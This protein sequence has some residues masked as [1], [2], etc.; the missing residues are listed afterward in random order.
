MRAAS[1]ADLA[2]LTEALDTDADLIET[3]DQLAAQVEEAIDSYLG[4]RDPQYA[5]R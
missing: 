2:L 5:N 4:K 1:L 3:L